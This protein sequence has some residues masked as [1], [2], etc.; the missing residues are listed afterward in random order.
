MTSD[1]KN[2]S[3][4]ADIFVK[5]GLSDIVFSPG[6]R[7]APFV[8]AF[9]GRSDVRSLRIVDE[10]SAGFYALGMAQQSGRAV[11]VAC[12]SGSAVLNYAP[13]IAEAYYQKIPL[14]VLTAD[15]PLEMIDKGDGQTIRQKDVYQNYIKKSF[16]LPLALDDPSIFQIAEQVINKAID[17]TQYPEPG[18]VHIN[19]PFR[20]PLYKTTTEKIEGRVIDTRETPAIPDHAELKKR[21]EIWN[22]SKQILLI[23]GQMMPDPMLNKRLSALA[24]LD[25]VVVLTETTS[26]MH[27]AQFIDCI[28]NVVSTIK[29]E[30]SS[31]FQPDL[32]VSFG[33]HVVSKMIKR[34]LR[35]NPPRE[36]WHISLSGE[37]MDTYFALSWFAPLRPAEFFKAISRGITNSDSTY[38]KKWSARKD[39]VTQKR[40]EF[41]NSIPFSDMQVF[42][43]L[44]QSIPPDSIMHLGNSTPV[45]YAQLFGADPG[46]VY[47]SNRGVSGIDGQVSTAAG[48][49]LDSSKLNTMVTGDLG[50]FYDSNALM[51]HHLTGNLKIIV[52]NNGGGGIFRFI[53]GPDESPFLE[54]FF[55]VRHDWRAED[56]ARAFGISYRKAE[57]MA[58]L[59]KELPLFYGKSDRPAILEVF[60]PS[61]ENALVLKNYFMS[62]K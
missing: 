30:E 58:S 8:L 39:Q 49:A 12:T 4:L 20:E 34:F 59:Q 11:A 35:L 61:E 14:L 17:E 48:Y 37:E 3:L 33:G 29:E 52:I 6:S 24:R 31:Q 32:I 53:P 44:L 62:L 57:D 46:Y 28:D 43:E 22:A 5:K 27:D 25:N 55:E 60:T 1:K 40:E 42:G 10:R 21:L 18:P 15:R 45:R 51:N 19:V 2:V 50:F 38:A 16:E 9:A 54:E 7:N 41:L 13:A 56:I 23:A 36:H 47:C 26:N